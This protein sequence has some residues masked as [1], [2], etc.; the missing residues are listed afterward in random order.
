LTQLRKRIG[1]EIFASIYGDSLRL[2]Q[3]PVL[4]ESAFE[5]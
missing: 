3:Q 4:F 2:A 1:G 5:V